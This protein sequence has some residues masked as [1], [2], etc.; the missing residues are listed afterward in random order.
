M[1]LR[2]ARHVGISPPLWGRADRSPVFIYTSMTIGL[3]HSLVFK[4]RHLAG[5][6]YV[7]R[8][9]STLVISQL[10]L[11][12]QI[13]GAQKQKNKVRRS[14]KKNSSCSSE[15]ISQR[16]LPFKRVQAEGRTVS[17]FLGSQLNTKS[18]CLTLGTHWGTQEGS[19]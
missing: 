5:W 13:A 12:S 16:Q 4:P 9:T 3:K 6:Q 11:L 17:C 1:L 19:S 14:Y 7:V 10:L 18:K 8:S 15:C 2:G